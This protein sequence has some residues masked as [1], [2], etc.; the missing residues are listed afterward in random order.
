MNVVVNQRLQCVVVPAVWMVPCPSEL[1]SSCSSLVNRTSWE[2]SDMVQWDF[3]GAR[4]V[5][6]EGSHRYAAARSLSARAP[7]THTGGMCLSVEVV[8]ASDENSSFRA[9]IKMRSFLSG[10]RMQL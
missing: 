10:F 1:G 3:C 7:A 9:L 2:M 5:H 8:T 4:Q 6:E